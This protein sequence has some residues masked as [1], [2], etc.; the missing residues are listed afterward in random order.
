MI[1][2]FEFVTNPL[3]ISSTLA[4][5]LI[6]LSSALIGVI[7]FLRKAR[8]MAGLAG[9]K[10]CDALIKAVTAGED[11][12]VDLPV[13]QKPPEREAPVQQSAV[14]VGIFFCL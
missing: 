7:T 13:L 5:V 4:S 3:F 2:F 8:A 9:V 1:S 14:Q 10:Q 12:D 11:V 6:S